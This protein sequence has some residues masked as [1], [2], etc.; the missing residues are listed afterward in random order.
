MNLSLEKREGLL[1]ADFHCHTGQDPQDNV[2]YSEKE[3]IDAAAEQGY[4]VLSITNHDAVTFGPEIEDYASKRGI[5]LLPGVEK[6]VEGKHVLLLNCRNGLPKINSFED[7]DSMGDHIAVIAPHPY[8]PRKKSLNSKLSAHRR[9]FDAVEYSHFYF[10]GI[11]PNR[12]LT[13]KA[14]KWGLPMVG[15]SDSHYL[16]Q[17]GT[18][19]SLVRSDKN[20][21]AVIEAIKRGRVEVV[22]RPLT[23]QEV[24]RVI[25]KLIFPHYFRRLSRR[26][27]WDR[28]GGLAGKP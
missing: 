2:V 19:Y 5:L 25:T 24:S 22:T 14:R 17:L 21:E 7:L 6:T 13:R 28:K 10:M 27:S 11:N 16:F 12:R 9:F 23:L 4:D 3:L 15:N 18:T 8:Y 26:L 1:K 20:P